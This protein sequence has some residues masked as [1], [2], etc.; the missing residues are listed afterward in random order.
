MGAARPL[1]FRKEKQ[2]RVVAPRLKGYLVIKR[3]SSLALPFCLSCLPQLATSSPA[4]RNE[5]RHKHADGPESKAISYRQ[6]QS[7]L[8]IF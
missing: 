4:A 1:N 2:R 6:H 5:V 8:I 7:L 3:F